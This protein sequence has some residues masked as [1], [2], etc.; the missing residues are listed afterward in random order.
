MASCRSSHQ[1]FDRHPF[2]NLFR[3]SRLTST[4]CP[5]NQE[6]WA[7]RLV[8]RVVEWWST[9]FRERLRLQHR[10]W[11]ETQEVQQNRLCRLE[12]N[13]KLV[14]EFAETSKI[15]DNVLSG[16]LWWIQVVIPAGQWIN[17]PHRNVA[18]VDKRTVRIHVLFLEI[19]P[20]ARWLTTNSF[21][22]IRLSQTPSMD[23]WN[24]RNDTIRFSCCQL[25]Q[26]H[27]F[28]S[29]TS[30]NNNKPVSYTWERTPKKLIV[31]KAIQID[32]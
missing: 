20:W 11:E 23:S 5:R 24:E 6:T 15:V 21:Q 12:R 27:S 4:D 2:S 28:S 32:R 9:I 26:S 10:T 30:A 17:Q 19:I 18:T 3:S 22:T 25:T 7:N 8:Q 16:S 14:L 29:L 31:D 1:S 13:K